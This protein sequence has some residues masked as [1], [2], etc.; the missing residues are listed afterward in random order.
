MEYINIDKEYNFLVAEGPAMRAS[1]SRMKREL[2]FTMQC[3]LQQGAELNP[4]VY[5]EVKSRYLSI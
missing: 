1:A 3:M 4:A 5:S 2:H